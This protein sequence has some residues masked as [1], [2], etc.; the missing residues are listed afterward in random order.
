MRLL[1]SFDV[2]QFREM[3][4]IVNVNRLAGFQVDAIHDTRRGPH[5]SQSEFTLKPFVD[6][7]HVQQSQEPAPEPKSECDR[8]FRFKVK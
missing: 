6:N 4:R 7:L 5:Q 8:G 3:R 1:N 2:L